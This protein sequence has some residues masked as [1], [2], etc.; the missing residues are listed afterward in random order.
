MSGEEEDIKRGGLVMKEFSGRSPRSSEER[1]NLPYA[2]S[3]SH[4][5][6]MDPKFQRV[7]ITGDEMLPVRRQST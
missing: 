5:L 3:T 4:F 7:R 6:D 2:A 1:P